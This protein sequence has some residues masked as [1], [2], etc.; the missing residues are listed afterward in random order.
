MSYLTGDL[1]G[2]FCIEPEVTLLPER[3]GAPLARGTEPT[4]GMVW[5]DVG[6]KRWRRLGGGVGGAEDGGRQGQQAIKIIDGPLKV[7]S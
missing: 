3:L 5:E 2:E 1:K 6:V 4:R 7:L